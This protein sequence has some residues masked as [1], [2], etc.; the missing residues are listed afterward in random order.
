MIRRPASLH[1]VPRC[2]EVPAL[3]RYYQ[4]AATSRRPS[5]LA[6]F[7]FAW[8]CHRCV[9]LIRSR[10]SMNARPADLDC[11]G[12]A[13]PCR[14]VF[15][16]RR[17]DLPSSWGTPIAPSP[18]SSTPAG[19]SASDHSRRRGS[20]PVAATSRAP[21]LRLSRLNPPALVLAVYASP[22]RSPAKDA[23]LASGC[24]SGSAGR[25]RSAGFQREVSE[26]STSHPPLPS[27]LG[28]MPHSGQ[29]SKLWRRS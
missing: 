3:R 25:A 14:L 15:R 10:G 27:L 26:C 5:R 13:S 1:A 7:S 23:R 2:G 16:W 8:R 18:G 12:S 4:G 9:L 11:F 6:S 21:A 20:A 28:A 19:P 22:R 24:W 17:Q 29:R